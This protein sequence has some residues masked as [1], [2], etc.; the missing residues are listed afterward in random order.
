MCEFKTKEHPDFAVVIFFML[1]WRN[2]MKQ[3]RDD[4]AHCLFIYHVLLAMLGSELNFDQVSA[5]SLFASVL[6]SAF[7]LHL[8]L[9]AVC[10]NDLARQHRPGKPSQLQSAP[11]VKMRGAGMQT[12][13]ALSWWIRPANNTEKMHTVCL[14]LT[15]QFTGFPWVV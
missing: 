10:I 7:L 9:W 8:F 1:S 15:M 13:T 14:L 6:P 4:S 5:F 3:T 2:I 11:T 12:Q